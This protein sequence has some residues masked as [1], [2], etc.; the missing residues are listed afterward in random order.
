VKGVFR[1]LDGWKLYNRA[2]A[3]VTLTS[4]GW[5]RDSRLELIGETDAMPKAETIQAALRGCQA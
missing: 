3:A 2:Y 5:R 4:S 1:T